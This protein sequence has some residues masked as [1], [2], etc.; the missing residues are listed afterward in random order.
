MDE[1]A[2]RQLLAAVPK[3]LARFAPPTLLICGGR[4]PPP[5]RWLTL[6]LARLVEQ[7]EPTIIDSAGHDLPVTHA[8][9]L[10][11]RILAHL[12]AL[13][14]GQPR[15]ERARDAFCRSDGYWLLPLGP[16]SRR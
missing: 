13:G 11:D 14:S 5:T 16:A 12:N 8:Q 6:G 2:R 9:E 10:D 1:G 7:G 3:S 4:S 15:A